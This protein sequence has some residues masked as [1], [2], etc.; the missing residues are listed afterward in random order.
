MTSDTSGPWGG[1]PASSPQ[2]AAPMP[3]A[4]P[5][6]QRVN[7]SDFVAAQRAN[8]RKTWVLI[9]FLIVLGFLVGYVLGWTVDAWGTNSNQFNLLAIS[10]VGILG[11]LIFSGVGMGA[12]AVT[13]LAGDK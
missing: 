2:P 10:A 3:P 6:V 8:R 4:T 7:S 13:L 5:P 1:H 12:A 9:L 11:G